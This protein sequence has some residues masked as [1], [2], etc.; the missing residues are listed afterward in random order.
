MPGTLGLGTKRR[1]TAG[2]RIAL[3]KLLID[4]GRVAEDIS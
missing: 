1:N 4:L 2:S 3:A